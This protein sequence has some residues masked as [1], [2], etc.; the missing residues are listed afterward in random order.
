MTATLQRHF[1]INSLSQLTFYF[2]LITM[3]DRDANWH[4]CIVHVEAFTK[5]LCR[6]NVY[7]MSGGSN[8]CPESQLLAT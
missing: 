6:E 2:I 1:I 4:T 7:F 8:Q 5:S 3:Q